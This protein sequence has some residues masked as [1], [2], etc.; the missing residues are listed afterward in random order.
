[1]WS[2]S[3]IRCLSI[4]FH[5]S[6][7]LPIYSSLCI[8]YH[9]SVYHFIFCLLCIYPL[10]VYLLSIIYLY[11]I[12]H[13]YTHHIASIYHQSIILSIDH[14]SIH[15]S[16]FSNYYLPVIYIFVYHLVSISYICLCWHLLDVDN[17]PLERKYLDNCIS[18]NTC[19]T[20]LL[21]YI[22]MMHVN[23][24]YNWVYFILFIW[25]IRKLDSLSTIA[26]DESVG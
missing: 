17:D 6:V 1:M 5:L 26:S 20:F 25:P 10:I 22:C 7:Y 12:Y 9:P 3:V 23:Q 18:L 16:I 14:L 13:L 19:L 11:I 24:F 4:Y 2:S 21:C 15:P 8:I